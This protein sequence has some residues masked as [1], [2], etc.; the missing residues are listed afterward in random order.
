MADLGKDGAL[1]DQSTDRIL[2]LMPG[3]KERSKNLVEL[4]ESARFIAKERPLEPDAKAAKLLNDD[5][6]AVLS[7][8]HG[9]LEALPDWTIEAIEN[10]VRSFSDGRELKLGKVAQP[11]RAALTGTNVSPGIFDVLAVLGREES[12]G[13]MA[14]CF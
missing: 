5:A 10:A 13:R 3:L 12:L 4:A 11:L 6:R 8:L 1:A 9:E 14:D 2:A 7:A